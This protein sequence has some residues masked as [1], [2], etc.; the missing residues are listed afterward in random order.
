MTAIEK[1]MDKALKLLD[2][3]AECDEPYIDKVEHLSGIRDAIDNW[4]DEL[5]KQRKGKRL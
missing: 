5:D 3:I 1:K 4:M 2:E